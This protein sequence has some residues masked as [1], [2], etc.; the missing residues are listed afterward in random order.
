MSPTDELVRLLKKLRLSGVLQTLELR[1]KEAADDDLAMTE[2]LFRLLA[3]EVE[4]REAKQLSLRLR[5]A[6]FEH[7]KTIE[8]FDFAFNPA[9]PKAKVLDL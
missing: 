3:D 6:S 1:M 4:R 9:V 8:D 5:R 2:F 7:A